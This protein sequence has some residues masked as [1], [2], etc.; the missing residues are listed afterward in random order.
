MAEVLA[1]VD[2]EGR[3]AAFLSRELGCRAF[4]PPVPP[5]LAPPAAMVE[6]DGGVREHIVGDAFNVTV[7]VWGSTLAGAMSMASR[8]A[9]AVAAL[10]LIDRAE[11]GIVCRAADLTALPYSAPDAAHPTIPR[12]RFTATLRVRPTRIESD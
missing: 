6:N 4:A 10:P 7:S 12:A 8:A 1:P 11:S 2:I 9:G 3:L 5:D